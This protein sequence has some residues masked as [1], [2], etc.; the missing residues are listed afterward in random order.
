MF[1]IY[2]FFSELS[3]NNVKIR[4]DAG[5]PDIKPNEIIIKELINNIRDLGYA[6]YKGLD[7][8]REIIADYHKVDINNVIITP[9]SKA[10]ISSLILFSDKVN[11]ISPY[12]SGYEF[13]ANL[14]NKK[15]FVIKT[16]LEENWAPNFD[17]IER[18][19]TLIINYPNNPT[20][21]IINNNEIKK[22]IDISMDRNVKII[23][24][25]AYRDILFEGPKFKITDYIIENS[26]S[27]FSFSK[28]FS[29]P[30]LRLGYAVG[31]K[32]LINKMGEFIKANITS[33]PKFSQ[34]AAIKAIEN[35][36]NI[37]SYVKNIYYNR[38]EIFLNNIDKKKFD[39]MKP[40]GTFYVFLRLREN[41]SGTKLAYALARK[42]LGI[43]PGE[44][45]GEDYTN[46]IRVSLTTNEKNIKEAT[47]LINETVDEIMR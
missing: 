29:L 12:W 24:D 28:T 4:M 8:L 6:P 32:N 19:S 41:V 35:W 3:K 14:F 45:F 11:L 1:D 33:V 7:E 38:L 39:Y 25:E 2:E 16:N 13:S 34:K 27:I 46:F 26:V 44:A 40:S 20:G 23:S 47:K 18:D 15:I 43:F 31:D 22:L 30:G 17:N 36:D 37:A 10:A 21:K 5:D 42:G 9:G